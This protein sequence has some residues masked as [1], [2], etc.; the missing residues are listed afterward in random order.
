MHSLVRKSVWSQTNRMK[1]NNISQKRINFI[2]VKH[3]EKNIR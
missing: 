2:V 1:N 3:E